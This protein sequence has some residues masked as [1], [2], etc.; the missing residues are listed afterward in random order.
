MLYSK[1]LNWGAHSRSKS[2]K[3]SIEYSMT[4][5]S[6]S[7]MQ[8][9]HISKTALASKKIAQHGIHGQAEVLNRRETLPIN[10]VVMDGFNRMLVKLENGDGVNFV[11]ELTGDEEEAEMELPATLVTTGD[12]DDEGDDVEEVKDDDDSN[13]GG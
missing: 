6:K 12:K 8:K 1:P 3:T 9:V 10:P 2:M 11:Y 4:L 13:K 5:I 7:L